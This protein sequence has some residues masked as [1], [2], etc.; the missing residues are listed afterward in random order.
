MDENIELLQYIYKESE[1]GFL[2]S[3]D[4]IKNLNDKENSI[5]KNVEEILKMYEA[6]LQKSEKLIKENSY[7]IEKNNLLTKIGSKIGITSEVNKD[8]SDSA[9]AKLLI[10]GLTM[11]VTNINSKIKKFKNYINNDILKLAKEYYDNQKK[12]IKKLE[13]YL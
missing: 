10:Q 11:G 2:S 5:K 1:M 6:F 12:S 3:Q 13:K 9:I 7:N 8:N 4:L